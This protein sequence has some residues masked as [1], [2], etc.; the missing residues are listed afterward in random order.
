VT[1]AKRAARGAALLVALTGAAAEAHQAG[2]SRGTYRVEQARVV[3][4][5]TFQ[6]GE[7]AA[8]V[9]G[10]DANRDGALSEEELKAGHPQIEAL[11]VGRLE[12]RGDERVC[13]GVLTSVRLVEG[14][15][16]EVRARHDCGAEP[17]SWS[18]DLGYLERLSRGHR[19]LSSLEA[20]KESVD[21]VAYAGK[22]ALRLTPG[23]AP[24]ASAPAAS[25]GEARPTTGPG[26][27]FLLGVEHILTGYD[28]LLFL[29][30]LVLVGGR[31]RSL[32]AVVTAFTVAHSITL[33]LAAFG[34]WSPAARL[35]EPA[36]ALSIAYVGVENFFVKDAEGRWRITFPFGLIHGFGFAG[37][38]AEIQLPRAQVAPALLLFNLGVEAGQLAAMAPMLGALALLRRSEWFLRRGVRLLSAGIV[39]AGLAWFVVRVRGGLSMTILRGVA[40]SLL[41][42]LPLLPACTCQSPAAGTAGATPSSSTPASGSAEIP[43]RD[44][45]VTPVYPPLGGPPHPLAARLCDAL[46]GLPRRRKAE[47][48]ASPPATS[49]EAECL[50][51]LSGALSSGAV[52][53]D[54]QDLARCEEASKQSLASC[55]WVLPFT[56]PPVPEACLGLLKGTRKAGAVCRSSLECEGELN[57]SGVGP[58]SAGRCLAARESGPCAFQV[59]ALAGYTRQSDAARRHPQC[60]GYCDRRRCAPLLKE[61]DACT[62]HDGCGPG[63][64]CGDG[65]C[66]KGEH[67]K[68]GEPC[69]GTRCAPGLRCD[70]GRCVAPGKEGD[71]CERHEQC[72]G[73]CVKRPGDG[74]DAGKGTCSASCS[75]AL[76]P[77]APASVAPS[78]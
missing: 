5:M 6:N 49:V 21:A 25:G 13:P 61:G 76:P 23:A 7:L 18:V 1:P 32:V 74:P 71:P 12:V 15:G 48:C 60:K 30:G 22:Q 26:A 63:H 33:A 62:S 78:P 17:R 38:L 10:A 2:L 72:R 53:L 65:R 24:A 56:A 27:L 68:E 36:I 44:P 59:D 3:S 73:S 51:N 67:G 69:L 29:L 70:R 45:E 34:L 50:R 39:A 46:H 77:R 37:A 19:Q 28:H 11:V 35:V 47:C 55:D 9:P 40:L 31:L 43:A 66:R 54:E 20:G 75:V 57:C 42:L 14:D 52:V 4:E 16:V 58:T 41:V 8:A 64:H